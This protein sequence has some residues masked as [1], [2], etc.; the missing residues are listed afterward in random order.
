M[1]FD[2]LVAL[3]INLA[4][5]VIVAILSLWI[6][7][8]V[9]Q[10]I[11][12]LS[13]SGDSIQPERQK[14]LRTLVQV[15][16]WAANVLIIT[17]ALLMLLGNFVDI[18]PLLASAG[19]A[20]L[21]ISLGAQSLIK[22]FICGL[23]ILIEGQYTIGDVIKVAGVSGVVE[24]LTLRTTHIRD[25]DGNLHI[26]P[27]GDVRVVSNVT[28]DWS[29]AVVDIGIAYEEDMDR[30]LSVLEGVMDTFFRDPDFE[31]QLLERPQVLGPLSLGDWAI[32]VRVMVKTQPGKQWGVAMALRRRILAACGRENVVLPYPRQEVWVRRPEG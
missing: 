15:V 23:L 6:V 28:R 10:R 27:N 25:V 16:R 8:F 17:I 31:S 22:D 24:R 20:G 1:G 26:V 21:A 18:T 9:S 2:N 13:Q 7:R 32:T 12:R 4:I 3:V 19:V 5:V 30:V 11:L 14:Q 29:R